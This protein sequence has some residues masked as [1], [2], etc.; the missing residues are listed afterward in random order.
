MTVERAV[1][2]D[3][4]GTNVF[5]NQGIEASLLESLAENE[6]ALCLW[7][8][9]SAV[10]IGRNQNPYAECRVDLLESE[11]GLLARRLS[12]GGAVYHDGGNL[13]FTF[14]SFKN[15]FDK[16][17]NLEIVLKAVRSLG[18]D[19]EIG[20][21]N[22]LLCGGAKFSGNA[23]Y[24]R[25][26]MSLHHGTLLLST[27]A[28]KV[29]RY[30][31]PDSRKF[32]GK[33]VRSV[34]S[35]VCALGDTNP[36]AADRGKVA[37]ALENAFREAYPQAEFREETPFGLGAEKILKW[38]SFFNADEWR[39]GK[40]T[41]FDLRFSAEVL[42]RFAEVFA[43]VENGVLSEVR[44]DTDCMD[45]DAVCAVEEKM[46]GARLVS[47]DRAELAEYVAEDSVTEEARALIERAA[48]EWYAV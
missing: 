42:G 31:T 46:K 47:R 3:N 12:G 28:D 29:A 48:K 16:A 8:N 9:D 44:I 26:E 43:K 7:S 45:A 34:S 36:A 33:S 25:G 41:E 35:R 40:K 2:I 4:P 30:L 20:G 15:N 27:S 38:T 22:D 24:S 5:V 13:N 39:Y 37:K 17:R 23:Y 21:R 14:A 10:V 6:T 19:A 18:I 32:V 11:G 1:F